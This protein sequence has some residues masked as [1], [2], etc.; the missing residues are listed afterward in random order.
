MNS[1][2]TGSMRSWL[3]VTATALNPMISRFLADA[4][5]WLRGA[6][7][8]R[9]SGRGRSGDGAQCPALGIRRPE[10]VCIA[11]S[12][13]E[14]AIAACQSEPSF[15]HRLPFDRSSLTHWRQRL[16][17]EQLVALIQESLSM[18]TR[19]GRWSSLPLEEDR[20]SRGRV[21]VSPSIEP[22]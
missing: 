19:P 20:L 18:A 17:E 13:K 11:T 8:V 9:G 1:L 7:R 5:G 3:I 12:P 22:A 6:L 4:I 15:C 21:G 2:P 10:P 16:G 14:A